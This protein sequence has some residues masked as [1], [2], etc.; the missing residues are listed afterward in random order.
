MLSVPAQIPRLDVSSVASL[1]LF[2]LI[3]L[4][5]A[6]WLLPLF[7]AQ[8]QGLGLAIESVNPV[9][10][11]KLDRTGLHMT[12]P[13]HSPKPGGVVVWRDDRWLDMWKFASDAQEYE[14]G[15]ALAVWQCLIAAYIPP[16]RGRGE[17]GVNLSSDAATKRMALDAFMA[18]VLVRNLETGA[19]VFSAAID[20]V[21]TD[22]PGLTRIVWPNRSSGED[23][24]NIRK[25]IQ[26]ERKK[27]E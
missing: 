11:V 5:H 17:R 16:K 6:V 15:I 10:A 8:I 2:E 3:G 26:R 27:A 7:S 4:P 19:G 14:G 9:A 21:A 13:A 24:H 1:I 23:P 25:Y 22:H 12:L 20:Q 18:H